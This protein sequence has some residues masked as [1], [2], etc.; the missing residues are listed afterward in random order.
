MEEAGSV[1]NS[2]VAR[3]GEAAAAQ[4][5]NPFFPRGVAEGCSDARPAVQW[6][7]GG[8]GRRHRGALKTRLALIDPLL[9]LLG[10]NCWILSNHWGGNFEIK[11]S[12]KT[13]IPF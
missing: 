13:T 12:R 4:I 5:K 3:A 2:M 9:Q 10:L 1:W 6:K 11:S 7:N 8:I